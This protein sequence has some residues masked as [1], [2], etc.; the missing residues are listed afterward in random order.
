MPLISV[1]ITAFGRQDY[2]LRSLLSAV[3]Q[4][5][6]NSKYEVLLATN[7]PEAASQITASVGRSSSPE[8][9]VL[10]GLPEGLGATV[11]AAIADSRGEILCF[12]D[13]DDEW[14]PSRL[15][16]VSLA[17]GSAAGV[18]F[19]K[20]QQSFIDDQ[21]RVVSSVQARRWLK[22][23]GLGRAK[24]AR[25]VTAANLLSNPR[26]MSVYLPMFNSSSLAV[27]AEVLKPRLNL[28][29]Q[30][31]ALIDL[32][33]FCVAMTSAV[34]VY[35]EPAPLTRYRIHRSTSNYG[36]GDP[37]R[38]HWSAQTRVAMG[39]ISELAQETELMEL[40]KLIDAEN[41]FYASRSD[42]VVPVSSRAEFAGRLAR[43]LVPLL[44]YEGSR[45]VGLTLLGAAYLVSPLLA[46]QC[47]ALLQ[48]H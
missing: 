39:L 11:A 23:R 8:I 47:F 20:N 9:R 27:R 14:E 22:Q 29:S 28:L 44:R 45:G 10:S 46:S 37:R 2:L 3:D 12:L 7:F 4:D 33:Y 41:V 13:D 42:L 48:S 1:I 26:L 15:S 32:A 5:L 24:V 19:Y 34:D 30:L 31:P 35:L 38:A 40:K 16:A 6:P 21:Q 17:F 25:R 18:G 43:G 36:P